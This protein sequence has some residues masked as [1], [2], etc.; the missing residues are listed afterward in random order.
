[1]LAGGIYLIF[2][3][4]SD[5]EDDED[6]EDEQNSS[7]ELIENDE[8]QEITHLP[9]HEGL[10]AGGEYD[11]STGVTWYILPDGNKWWMQDDG[12]FMLHRE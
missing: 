4:N 8:V 9:N 1:M 3:L 12:S 10:P 2:K 11:T 5:G 7:S 6:E